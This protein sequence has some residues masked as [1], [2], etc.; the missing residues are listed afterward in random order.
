MLGSF[1]GPR[2]RIFAAVI[3][4]IALAAGIWV[5]FFRTAGYQKTTATIV[6]IETDPDYVPDPNVSGD[7][8]RI[9]TVKY[10]VDGKEYTRA[11]DSDAPD[12]AVGKEIEV[13]VDPN[14]PGKVTSSPFFGILL[15]VVGG[16]LLVFIIFITV[17]QK[18][19][20]K[21]LKETRGDVTY[22]PSE[23]GA[24]RELYFLT[25]TGTPKYGHRIEDRNGNVLYEAKMTK[26][27][28]VTPYGFDF[29]DHVRGVTTPHLIG[30]EEESD[31]NS[32]LIDNHYTFTFDGED[33]W[34]HLKRS[35]ISVKTRFSDDKV[36]SA[37]Y[38][39]F[40]DGEPIAFF[41]T[42]SQYPREDEAAQHKIASK[43]AVRG[44]YRIQTA[45]KNLDLLFVTVLAFARSGALDD[46]GG[47]VKSV[48]F[49]ELK[50]K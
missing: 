4:V 19:A 10:T 39:V 18:S 24:Q 28:P 15:M 12:Y 33:I 48:L 35:G 9:V 47:S 34:K 38:D 50:R 32:L 42:T 17:K 14:D 37:A 31:W 36:L 7:T 29:I 20:V 49:N 1:K 45:E 8:K 23:K 25:D 3:A 44:F 2:L 11:L 43:M 21:N 13:Q 30:H 41:E 26:F 6:S 27:S 22:L 46:K 40:R 16:A 5:T